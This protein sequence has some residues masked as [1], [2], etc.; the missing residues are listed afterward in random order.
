MSIINHIRRYHFELKHLMV[1]FIV[2]I[3]FQLTVSTIHKISLQNLLSRTAEWYKKDSAAQLANL[4]TISL[5]L[6]LEVNEPDKAMGLVKK[7]KMAR[8][9]NIILNQQLLQSN[10][11]MMCVIVEDHGLVKAIDN[12]QTFIR[13]LANHAI[14]TQTDS[15]YQSAIAQYKKENFLIKKNETTVSNQEDEGIIHVFVPLVPNGEYAGALYMKIKPDLS[16]INH[17]LLS[18]YDQT[19]IIFSALILFGLMAMFYI[20]SYSVRERDQAQEALYKEQEFRSIE[21]VK[22]DKESQFTK[23]IYHTHHK[24]EKV[25]GFIK[26]DIR[27]LNPENLA[28]IQDRILKY[29]N[30]VARAIYDMKWFEPPVQTIRG[31]IFKTDIN[32]LLRFLVENYFQRLSISNQFTEFDL[33]LDPLVPAVQINMYVVWEIL[34]PLIQNS[35]DHSKQ[36]KTKIKLITKYDEG[37]KSALISISD[38]G[39]GIDGALFEKT[40]QG[41]KKIF[42]ENISTKTD[43]QNSG[44]GC[45]LAYQ[46]CKRCDWDLD[47]ENQEASGAH[48]FIIIENLT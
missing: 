4:T 37:E 8:A 40:E 30:F 3:F 29:S 39:P 38:N 11:K 33:Q 25:M 44:Y 23:R 7:E 43:T 36:E 16:F 15:R 5:E 22:H 42:L 17:Q 45:Y 9:F 14:S 35:I 31:P 20:S 19:S 41:I 28:R 46:I 47:A 24:A 26:E 1:L 27:S 21:Q 18:S 13:F 2:L 34:E 12:G 32:E 6:L 10:V 48:F